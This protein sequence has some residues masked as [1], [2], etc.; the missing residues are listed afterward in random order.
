MCFTPPP[1]GH[2]SELELQHCLRSKD[3]LA[4]IDRIP[5]SLTKSS[6]RKVSNME[7]QQ[8]LYLQNITKQLDYLLRT[9]LQNGFPN[10]V[11]DSF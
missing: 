2:I 10:G 11:D 3:P 5:F 7:P 8:R 1:E 9:Q 6:P 4:E